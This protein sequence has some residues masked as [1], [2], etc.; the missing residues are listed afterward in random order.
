MV[1]MSENDI[2]D[3]EYKQYPMAEKKNQSIAPRISHICILQPDYISPE[4]N[5]LSIWMFVHISEA[6]RAHRM[7]F[8]FRPWLSLTPLK[9]PSVCH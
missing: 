3:D 7:E 2:G 6:G 9:L 4:T 1:G 5:E 8:F